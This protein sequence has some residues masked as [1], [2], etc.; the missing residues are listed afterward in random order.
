M[1]ASSCIPVV[2]VSLVGRAAEHAMAVVRAIMKITNPY[3]STC[4]GTD[5]LGQSTGFAPCF[6]P[7]PSLTRNCKRGRIDGPSTLFVAAL[8]D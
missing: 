1:A 2:L 4:N 5:H 7:R 8:V 3:S 6:G